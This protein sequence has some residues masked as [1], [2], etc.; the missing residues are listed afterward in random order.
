MLGK[1]DE[2]VEVIEF[3]SA[4]MRKIGIETLPAGN[5]LHTL[6]ELKKY[7]TSKIS[8]LMDQ[9]Y[10][11]LLNA[12]YLIDLDEEKLHKLFS[13]HNRD[14]I[15]AALADMIIERQIQKLHFRKRYREGKI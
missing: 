12:L 1:K 13:S 9:D 5:E 15:P 2:A 4:D 10:N 7:L 11:K 8:E 6:N 3:I 14:F